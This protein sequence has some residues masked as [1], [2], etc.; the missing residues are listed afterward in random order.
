MEQRSW[1]REDQEQKDQVIRK[2]IFRVLKGD[3]SLRF[4]G[5]VV[6]G[7]WQELNCHGIKH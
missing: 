4:S 3:G 2:S 6:S 5:S 1:R 7:S